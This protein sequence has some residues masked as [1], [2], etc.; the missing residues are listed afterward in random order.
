MRV[1][2]LLTLATAFVPAPR[3]APLAP[4]LG[5][6]RGR[7]NSKGRRR[8]AQATKKEEVVRRRREGRGPRGGS[9]RPETEADGAG[10]HYSKTED[11]EKA[12]E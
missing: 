12:R 6:K 5:R 10:P 8:R 11:P 4:L 9:A 3:R 1:V 7:G 2:L